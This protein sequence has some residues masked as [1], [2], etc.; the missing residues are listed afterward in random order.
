MKALLSKIDKNYEQLLKESLNVTEWN[1]L[2][3]G[4]TYKNVLEAMKIAMKQAFK[5]GRI[6]RGTKGC[7]WYETYDDYI[8]G[9]EEKK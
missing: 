4:E 7:E 2:H 6:L 1:F 5:A 3:S 9:L 8:K